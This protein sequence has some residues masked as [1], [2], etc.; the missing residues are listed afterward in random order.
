L[1]VRTDDGQQNGLAQSRLTGIK[2]NSNS[3]LPGTKAINP[4]VGIERIEILDVLRGFALF[5]VVVVNMSV[6]WSWS[7]SLVTQTPGPADDIITHLLKVFGTGKFITIFSFLFGLGIA[8]QMQRI[9]ARGARY[10]PIMLR[11]LLVLLLIG[12]MHYLLIG[13][14][15]ILHAYAVLGILLLFFHRCRAKALLIAAVAIMLLNVGQPRPLLV[16]AGEKALTSLRGEPNGSQSN[17]RE[18]GQEALGTEEEGESLQQVYRIYAT[19]SYRDILNANVR[20]FSDYMRNFAVRWWLGSLFPLLLLGAYVARRRI[21]ENV[22]DHLVLLRN[23]FWWGL[24]LGLAGSS[25]TLLGETLFRNETLP[26]QVRQLKSLSDLIGIRALGFAYASGT[27]LLFQ[28]RKWK[29]RLAPL[30]AVG[31]TAFTNYLLQTVAAVALFYGVGLGLYGKVSPVLGASLAVLIFAV[32]IRVSTWWLTKFR[33]GPVEWLW[34]SLTY[35]QL[36]RVLN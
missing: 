10:F 27:V 29:E 17:I 36:Q 9:A 33:F 11:R 30:A 8:M 31:R 3:T 16:M 28:N 32:Q 24:A 1:Q 18:N 23:V 20:D 14:T 15:D 26:F 34:R 7:D 12:L 35:G 13:W 6:D 25:L 5:G 19:G 4:T 22:E 2:V 21:L